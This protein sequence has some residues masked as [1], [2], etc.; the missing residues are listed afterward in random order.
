MSYEPQSNCWQNI[1]SRHEEKRIF[2]YINSVLLRAKEG[3]EKQ[4]EK[5]YKSEEERAIIIGKIPLKLTP[6]DKE[7]LQDY[8][9]NIRL[10]T[11]YRRDDNKENKQ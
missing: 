3:I 1:D 9:D 8:I 10:A 7:K 5:R 2:E 11:F 6:R 4:L